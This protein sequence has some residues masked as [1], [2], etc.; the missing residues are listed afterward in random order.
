MIAPNELARVPMGRCW[1]E[2]SAEIDFES[3]LLATADASPLFFIL[4]I[5]CPSTRVIKNIQSYPIQFRL[6]PNNMFVVITLPYMLGRSV[7]GVLNPIKRK[8]FTCTS[9]LEVF[10]YISPTYRSKI[11]HEGT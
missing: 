1:G 4:R 6:I 9:F 8:C 10:M 5:F 11:C 2:A 7:E 3:P